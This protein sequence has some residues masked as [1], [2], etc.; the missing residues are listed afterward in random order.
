[1]GDRQG[2]RGRQTKVGDRQGW[3][4]DR[5][6]RQTRVG[7]RHGW[8]QTRA[9]Y[10]VRD[11][12]GGRQTRWGTDKGAGQTSWET[13]KGGRQIRWGLDKGGGQTRVGDIQGERQT[14]WETRNRKYAA[15]VC[16]RVRTTVYHVYV[17]K[18]S[19]YA[20]ECALL[21]LQVYVAVVRPAQSLSKVDLSR[22]A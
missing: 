8:R 16:V 20:T 12:Q 19:E 11:R 18:L 5:G 10:K 9:T 4:T 21:P 7:D 2:G 17:I 6:G 14:R 1:M 13:D 3:A 15:R 22:Y